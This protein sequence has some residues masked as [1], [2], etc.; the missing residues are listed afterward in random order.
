VVFIVFSITVVIDITDKIV[1][2]LHLHH[3]AMA[4]GVT[5]GDYHE[6]K[7]HLQNRFP[8]AARSF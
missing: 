7:R 3:D 8:L 1:G 5:L 4:L 6:S 2:L